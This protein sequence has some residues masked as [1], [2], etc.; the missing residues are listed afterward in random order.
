MTNKRLSSLHC[1]GRPASSF[2][3]AS[4]NV[5]TPTPVQEPRNT[6]RWGQEM[7]H[8]LGFS[9]PGVKV[10]VN[11]PRTQGWLDR[12]RQGALSPPADLG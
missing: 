1:T 3:A 7:G 11:N 8:P 4:T 9:S 12:A 5:S 2:I 6:P 10:Q